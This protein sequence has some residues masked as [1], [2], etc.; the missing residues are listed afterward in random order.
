M[1]RKIGKKKTLIAALAVVLAA[2]LLIALLPNGKADTSSVKVVE[3]L[4]SAKAEYGTINTVFTSG[5][6]ISN[7]GTESIALAGSVKLRSWE[8]SEGDYVEAGDLLATVDRS[9]VLQ[10][11]SELDALMQELDAALE[12][13]RSDTV[14]SVLYSPI[15]GTV[16]KV[17][18]ESGADVEDTVYN[19]AALI[20][21]TDNGGREVNVVGYAGTVSAVY[22]SEGDTVYS[23]QSLI[24]L[25]D[26]EYTGEYERLLSQRRE[27]EAQMQ[28]LFTAYERG[29][30]YAESSGRVTGLNEDILSSTGGSTGSGTHLAVRLLSSPQ[31]LS[32]IIIEPVSEDEGEDTGEGGT[33]EPGGSEEPSN[34]DPVEPSPEPG[35]GKT[36]EKFGKV[37]AVDEEAGTVTVRLTDGSDL[38]LDA[39]ELEA[40]GASQISV[41]NILALGYDESGTLVSVT[42]YSSGGQ[43]DPTGGGE[44][45]SGGMGGGGMSGGTASAEDDTPKDYIMDE[46]ELCTLTDYDTAEI[47]LTVDEL[48]IAQ[49][50]IGQAV[51][52][53]LDALP[54]QSFDG[55]IMEID[56]NGEN[57]GGSTKYSVTVTLP[58]TEDMLTGMNAAVRV[59]LKE[60]DGRLLIPLAAVQEDANGIY[61]CTGYDKS[62]DEATDPIEITTGL[63]DGENV[64]VLSG[65]SEGDTVYYR[66]ADTLEYSFVK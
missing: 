62:S 50:S 25:S 17:Y 19:N 44:M 14:S 43:D 29:G 26:T 59:Q 21:L 7:S 20:V 48:D 5:G 64:E 56:P 13:S 9:S 63:S 2:A 28:A 51:T 55:E 6:A 8:V 12:S 65:L 34:P 22:V 27:L 42:V 23:G 47:T 15:D 61:V 1:L 11:I 4:L 45:P 31:R 35:D 54:G 33:T 39:A 3:E 58:R 46:T 66:Y 40:L 16:T 24:Y 18:A 10:A 52:V 32:A 41:G 36:T 49:L 60:N 53:T 38:T 37:T 57:S 30:V